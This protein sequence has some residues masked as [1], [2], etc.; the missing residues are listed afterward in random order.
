MDNK[1]LQE[2]IC[3]EG[4]LLKNLPTEKIM[5]AFLT[6][7]QKNIELEEKNEISVQQA[8]YN[9]CG[10]SS[11]QEILTEF[12]E[13]VDIACDLELDDNQRELGEGDWKRLKKT[14]RSYEQL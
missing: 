8:A 7:C 1:S 10:A 13:I 14:I 5:G 11:T 2:Q 3:H 9:I 12:S 6:Y 4:Y